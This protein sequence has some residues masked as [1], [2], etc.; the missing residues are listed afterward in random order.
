MYYFI[1]I[2]LAK[3]EHLTSQSWIAMTLGLV[4]ALAGLAKLV[5]I[6]QA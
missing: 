1:L 6:T 3:K 5:S 2:L 4:L